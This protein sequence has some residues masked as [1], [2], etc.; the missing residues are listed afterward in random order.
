M[1]RLGHFRDL[2]HSHITKILVYKR[3]LEYF[4]EYGFSQRGL[5]DDIKF[6][7]GTQ[8]IELVIYH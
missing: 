3:V 6:I 4:I 8:I 7:K 2:S 1:Q 5:F